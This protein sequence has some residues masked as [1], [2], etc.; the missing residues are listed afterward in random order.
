MFKRKWKL[1]SI[2]I[3]FVCLVVL[4]SL[5]ITDLLI[6]NITTQRIQDDQEEKAQIVSRTVA[7]SKIVKEGLLDDQAAQSIQNYTSEV[8]TITDMMFIVVLDM[9]GIRKS[10]PDPDL[11]GKR[12]VGGD[13]EVVLQGDEHI[14]TS[15]G[16]LG[17]SLRAFTP[18]YDNNNNQIGA[19]VVGISLEQVQSAL[20]Q[21]HLNILKGTVFGL[22]AGILG[23]ILVAK[24]IKRMLFGLEPYA[25]SK[26]LE[27]RSTMLQSVHEGIVA[28]DQ[29]KNI[30]LV[31][32][33]A[34]R[35]FKLAGLSEE[36]VGM[37]ISDYMP[38]S[39]LDRVLKTGKPE[40]DEEQILNGVSILVNREPLIV[41]DQ[42]IGAI[43]T[44]RDMTEM[45]H[46]AKQLTGI[47]TYAESL[48]AQSHEFMNRLHV[49][50]G[51]VQLEAYDELMEFIRKLVDH[52]NKEVDMVTKSIKDP[53]LAGFLMGKISYAREENV[54]LI[55]KSYSTIEEIFEPEVNHELI[56]IIGNLVDNAIQAL[57]DC[58]KKIIELRLKDEGGRLFIKVEDTGPGIKNENSAVIFE[59]GYSTKGE[60]RGFGLYL[61]KKS[62]ERLN[63]S[64]TV[65]SS[66]EGTVFSAEIQ[67]DTT[68]VGIE[69]D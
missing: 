57:A 14:S 16:T 30:T 52:N 34:L 36:P 13:E 21:G 53:V 27:E 28:V 69:H 66:A 43:S 63:G 67:Y 24:Y 38:S 56:T 58:E 17:D 22:L 46:L 3:I 4:L 12:F 23:A 11:I 5:L 26:L 44:F 60:D 37:K 10:H 2:I 62:I 35:I 20:L 33:S 40:R 42:V 25:I 65:K 68:R 41:D 32:K 6:S 49:I 48:R 59:K 39:R 15:E 51:M 54:E 1:S 7:E 18:V 29:D 50:F 31:N 45:N 8:Q 47:R 64:L 9:E 61:V 55:V 19:V